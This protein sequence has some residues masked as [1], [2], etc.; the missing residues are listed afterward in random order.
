MVIAHKCAVPTT[1][2]Y[3]SEV[4]YIRTSGRNEPPRKVLTLPLSAL[5]VSVELSLTFYSLPPVYPLFG[6][7]RG[8][9]L[10]LRTLRISA[11]L[12]P[13]F[14]SLPPVYPLFGGL[15]GFR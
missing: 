2:W 14:Y 11:D 9:A 8:L 4:N 3:P 5:C 10:S 7:L 13:T 6:G 12:S 1:V 15:R